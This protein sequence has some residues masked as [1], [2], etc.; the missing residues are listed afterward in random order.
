MPFSRTGKGA[1]VDP[2]T[3]I[4]VKSLSVSFLLHTTA[5]IRVELAEACSTVS[6]VCESNFLSLPS[7]KALPVSTMTSIPDEAN[8]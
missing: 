3:T 6:V 1:T 4:K 7:I 2:L 5:S 8:T